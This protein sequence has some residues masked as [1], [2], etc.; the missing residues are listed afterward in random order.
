[1][2]GDT[3]K[4]HVWPHLH[5]WLV[6]AGTHFACTSKTEEECFDRMLFLPPAGCVAKAC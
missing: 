3:V 1:M 4:L 5:R 6:E 2:A